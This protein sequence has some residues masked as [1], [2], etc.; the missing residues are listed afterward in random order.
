MNTYMREKLVHAHQQDIM[1]E[2]EKQRLLDKIRKNRPGNFERLLTTLRR[3]FAVSSANRH[4]I[5]LKNEPLTT[6]VEV[7][8]LEL[9][10]QG[11]AK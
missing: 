7:P 6:K 4:P 10:L 3:L 9:E 8:E 1:R 2:V 11:K 5:E